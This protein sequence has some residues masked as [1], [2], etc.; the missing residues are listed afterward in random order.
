MALEAA[1]IVM[2]NG[3]ST[4]AA[5]RTFTNI[6]RGYKEEGVSAAWRLDF[7]AATSAGED[8]W[9]TVVRPVGPSGVNLTRV[10]EVAVLAE[11]VAQ[12]EVA[13][14]DLDAEV[15]RIKK[16]PSPYNRWLAMMAAACLSGAL[17][18]FA[19]GD[20]GS[21]GIAFVAAGVGQV[22]RS[23]LQV[24]NVAAAYVTLLC[25][26]LSACTASVALRAGFSQE[27]PVTLIASVV[28]LAPGLPLINGFADVVS[29][30]F[31]VVG[32]E[33]IASAAY[34]FL[35]LAIAIALAFT[36]IL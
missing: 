31:L 27:A 2:Q 25:G 7:I 17:S 8:R 29:H 1:L 36:V 14:A 11:Q 5:S 22:L 34:L 18:Q 6:L 4:V 12:G 28:Y 19:G 21:L 10:S 16:L 32:I 20:W 26:V 23:Q 33:R 15:A 35:I 13:V 30:K 9:S 3:G 24:R